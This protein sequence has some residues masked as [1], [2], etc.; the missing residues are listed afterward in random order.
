MDGHSLA[1]LMQERYPS[2]KVLYTSGYTFD[3]I[4][5]RG[6]LTDEMNFIPKPYSLNTL[7]SRV[8]EVLDSAP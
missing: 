8:R 2:I 1:I 6:I 5:E 7:S 4:A 3:V